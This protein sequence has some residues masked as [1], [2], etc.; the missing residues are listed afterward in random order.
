MVDEDRGEGLGIDDECDK[1]GVT[2][3]NGKRKTHP[4]TMM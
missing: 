2:S 4:Q 1:M 3:A